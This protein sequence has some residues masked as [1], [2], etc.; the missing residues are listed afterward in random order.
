MRGRLL[1]AG[2]IFLSLAAAGPAAAQ[3]QKWEAT[4]KT[5]MSI[6]GDIVLSADR[7]TMA[8]KAFPIQL[9][10]EYGDARQM[11]GLSKVIAHTPPRR[12]RV[13]KT[14][15]EPSV[16][17]ENGNNLCGDAATWLFVVDQPPG[18]FAKLTLAVFS[19]VDEPTPLTS[20]RMLCGTYNYD[21]PA[22]PPPR[23]R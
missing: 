20:E 18:G 12:V 23:R 5:A 7:L 15:I 10:R 8:G 22:A 9:V 1:R 6:T 11:D 21:L 14:R 17:L 3:G 4:S 13:Y 16:Q 19:G 2:A